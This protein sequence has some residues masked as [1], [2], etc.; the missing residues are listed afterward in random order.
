MTLRFT[1]T[2]LDPY[3]RFFEP[4]LSPFTNAVVGGTVRVS[5]EL[6][7]MNHLLVDASVEQLDLKLFDYPL[8][9]SGPIELALDRN[10]VR[11]DQLKLEGDG[12]A[13]EVTGTCRPRGAD[14]RRVGPGG[15]QPRHP[16]GLLPGRSQLRV[17]EPPSQRDRLVRQA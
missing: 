12:T 2:S 14:D 9:N 4:R 3:V 16:A 15:C 17:R 11:I 7:D 6:A 1:E 8:R 5:G 10:V 13:L